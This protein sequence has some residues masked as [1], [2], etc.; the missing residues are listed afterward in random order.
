MRMREKINPKESDGLMVFFRFPAKG[1]EL[2]QRFGHFPGCFGSGGGFVEIN[3][4]DMK[5]RVVTELFVRQ[6]PALEGAG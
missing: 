6:F 2:L 1:G 5:M 3:P 4:R